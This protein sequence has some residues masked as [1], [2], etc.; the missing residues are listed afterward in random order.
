M[1]LQMLSPATCVGAFILSKAL[2]T[3]NHL[4]HFHKKKPKNIYTLLEI[5]KAARGI[6]FVARQIMR[7]K[8]ALL[9][10]VQTTYS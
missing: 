4:F 7:V 10:A 2:E 1:P 5:D 3:Y 9:D 8:V 6:S